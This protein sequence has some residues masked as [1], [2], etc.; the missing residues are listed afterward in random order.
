MLHLA[1]PSTGGVWVLIF[2]NGESEADDFARVGMAW[3]MDER[4]EVLKEMGAVFYEDVGACGDI[5]GDLE[6]G[7][8]IGRYWE[9]RM[10]E[11]EYYDPP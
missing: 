2:K 4:A 9:E 10:K 7:R 11:M 3:T 8:S 1:Y 5:A 6:E